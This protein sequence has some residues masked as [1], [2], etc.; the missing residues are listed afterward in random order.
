MR[1][2]RLEERKLSDTNDYDYY[3]MHPYDTRHVFTATSD[4]AC[5][6]LSRLY[7]FLHPKPCV[8]C[9]MNSFFPTR[10]Y[11]WLKATA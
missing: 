8:G 3:D 11:L 5:F 9:V 6:S 2:K 4:H 7:L 10:L 1:A